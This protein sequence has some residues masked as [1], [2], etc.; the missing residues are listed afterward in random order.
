MASKWIELES[1]RYMPVAKRTPVVLVRGEG[2]RVWDEDGKSYLDL[3]GGWAVNTLG[4]SSPGDRGRADRAGVA[5]DP[6]L[7]PVLHRAAARAGRAAGRQTRCFDRVFFSNSGVEANEGAVKLARKYGQHKRNGA[8]DGHHHRSLVPRPHAGD[9]DGDRQAGLQAGLRPAAG[10]LPR[11]A[12]PVQRPRGHQAGDD[13]QDLR[14]DGRAGPGRGRRQPGHQRVPP[15][16]A[17]LV[18]REHLLLIFDEVQTGVGR[19]GTLWGYEL[20]G[21]EPD[22]MTLAE[23]PRRR[24]AD[25]RD[26]L[27]GEG[28]T[29]SASA[30]TARPSAATRWRRRWRWR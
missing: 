3:V 23:G 27:Q 2:C 18:R 24:R 25:R 21:V 10:W 14:R 22:V 13:R 11:R 30:T 20:F 19:L 5:A 26:P 8:Y 4:H 15:G 16:P 6:H 12:R 1:Q 7:E 28:R 17:R 29:S 9:A